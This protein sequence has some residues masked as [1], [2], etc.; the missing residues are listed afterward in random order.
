MQM[1]KA[2]S[3]VAM[4]GKTKA[5]L[6]R[7]KQQSGAAKLLVLTDMTRTG[8]ARDYIPG[9]PKNSIVI[10]RDY[11][12]PNREA[13]ARSLAQLCRKYAIE[14]Y[15]AGDIALAEKLRCGLHLRET[16]LANLKTFSFRMQKKNRGLS[17]AV[18]S[19]AAM[20]KARKWQADYMLLSPLFITRSHAKQPQ[21]GGHKFIR[22][23]RYGKHHGGKT[24]LTALGGVSSKKAKELR[25]LQAA[26]KGP[27]ALGFIDAVKK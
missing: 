22:L 2:K 23:A 9:L 14:L 11:N 15:I 4:T 1:Q 19:V 7:L 5:S 21:L 27:M 12:L 17:V 6:G 24:V 16:D 20:R 18:H 13:Y 3:F 10:L 26:H 25:N 8:D